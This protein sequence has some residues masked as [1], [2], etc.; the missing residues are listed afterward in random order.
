MRLSRSL[1]RD[2]QSTHSG[3]DIRLSDELFETKP[4]FMG[5]HNGNYPGA[6]PPKVE[7]RIR[8]VVEYPCLHLFSGISKIGDVRVDYSRPEATINADVFDFIKN[9]RRIWRFVLADPP[10]DIVGSAVRQEITKVYGIS[11]A[12]NTPHQALLGQ[13]L[14]GHADNVLWFDVT[15]PC[16]PGFYRHKTW[17]FI[18]GGWRHI[19]ALTW[20]K[21][22]RERL[23]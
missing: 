20:L 9:D 19:R 14:K 10:Y 17:L 11:R 1:G 22:E 16:P 4:E 8:K 18:P 7:E 13:Y 2:F 5:F 6:F 15:S 23:A 3:R 12:L 21:R